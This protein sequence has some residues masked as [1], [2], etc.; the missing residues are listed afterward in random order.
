MS[1]GSL[2]IPLPII[3]VLYHF[4][5]CGSTYFSLENY[6]RDRSSLR[7]ELQH[8]LPHSSSR[9][10]NKPTTQPTNRLYTWVS[11]ELI[12][13]NFTVLPKPYDMSFPGF[14][15]PSNITILSEVGFETQEKTPFPLEHKQ[16]SSYRH[17]T[18]NLYAETI[19]EK[20]ISTAYQ[21]PQYRPQLKCP[22]VTLPDY[23]GYIESMLGV[24]K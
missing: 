17:S 9:P 16:D 22:H 21:T 23:Y 10:V 11:I 14:T 12:Y 5:L 4:V 1:L 15:N 18:T 3:L 8:R 20:S 19:T 24:G 7:P 13:F 2:H 6:T